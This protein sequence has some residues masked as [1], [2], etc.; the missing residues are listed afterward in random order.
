MDR[1]RST[2]VD[3]EREVG[4]RLGFGVIDQYRETRCHFCTTGY[5]TR[6]LAFHPEAFDN[7]THLIID[8]VH[9][10][11]VD[12]DILCLLSKRLLERNKNI[13][14]ILMSA[15]LAAGIYKTYVG[16]AS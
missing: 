7:H 8:E 13:S 14:L 5:L 4:M 9:E 1:V 3:I 16:R 12:T 11:S 10:R 6:L 2:N 15:T